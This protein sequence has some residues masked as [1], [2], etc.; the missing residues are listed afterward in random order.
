[1]IEKIFECLYNLVGFFSCTGNIIQLFAVPFNAFLHGI[2][3]I[4]NRLTRLHKQKAAQSWITRCNKLKVCIKYCHNFLYISII[5]ISLAEFRCIL[6]RFLNIDI[7]LKIFFGKLFQQAQHFGSVAII[8]FCSTDGFLHCVFIF[9]YH[10]I[11][12]TFHNMVRYRKYGPC[13]RCSNR[14]GKQQ[15]TGAQQVNHAHISHKRSFRQKRKL[16]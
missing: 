3:C 7:K 13:N 14:S 16:R 11:V 1:M 5:H 10:T 9:R 4:D 6:E 2:Q 12:V 15:S 8:T